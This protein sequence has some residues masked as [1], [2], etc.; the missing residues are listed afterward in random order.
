VVRGTG[1][2][3]VAVSVNGVRR[4]SD[5]KPPFR[6]VLRTPRSR[7]A[8]IRALVSVAGDRFLTLDGKARAC[9]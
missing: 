8:A 5:S 9:S 2:A 3:G 6:F 1:V 7:V 4:A